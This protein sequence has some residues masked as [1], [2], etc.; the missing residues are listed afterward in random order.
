MKTEPAKDSRSVMKPETS[1][2]KVIP[3]KGW[4]PERSKAHGEAMVAALK[5]GLADKGVK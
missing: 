5:K 3:G 2:T 1:S 4:T